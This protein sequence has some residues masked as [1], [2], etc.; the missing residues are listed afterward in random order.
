MATDESIENCNKSFAILGIP[1]TADSRRRYREAIISTPGLETLLNG[2]IL[3]DETFDQTDSEGIRLVDVLLN[4]GII[5]GIKMD[6]G[7]SP[8]AGSKGEKLTV[9]FDGMDSRLETYV[10]KGALFAKWRAEF[11]IGQDTPSSQCIKGN[12]F[13]LARFAVSCLQHGVVPVLEPELMMQGPCSIQSCLKASSEILH[14]VINELY[15]HHINL[16][17][18]IINTNMILGNP[19]N[20]VEKSLQNSIAENSINCFRATVPA[21]I[22]T[23]L[24]ISSSLSNELAS[25]LLGLMNNSGI[26][27]P[28]NLSFSFY[29]AIQPHFL[30]IWNGHEKTKKEAQNY[31]YEQLSL[32]CD[33]SRGDRKSTD[34]P[35]HS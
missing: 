9:G 3:V 15:D 13:L 27:L 21:Q 5:P 26:D 17:Y 29:R 22:P 11:T 16:Q 24:L 33:A 10:Q 30:K 31:L 8:M 6:N 1:K 32:A 23:I 34:G 19:D 35:H 20:I 12:S 4:K 28:W 14:T 18:V 25:S 2:V 7:L